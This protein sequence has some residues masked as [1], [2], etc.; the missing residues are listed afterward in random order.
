MNGKFILDYLIQLDYEKEYI[1]CAFVYGDTENLEW[2][3]E[4]IKNPEYKYIGKLF[5]TKSY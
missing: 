4:E 1:C 3:L 2:F 5:K